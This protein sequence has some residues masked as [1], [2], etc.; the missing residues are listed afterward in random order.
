[1]R[2][3]L[4]LL[5]ALG[6][7]LASPA[8]AGT[9]YIPTPDTGA[10]SPKFYAEVTSGGT[11]RLEVTFINTGASGVGRTGTPA[12][13]DND[14][15]P[16][17]FNLTRYVVEVGMLRLVGDPG[18]DVRT[19][20]VFVETRSGKYPWALPVLTEENRFRTGETA[21]LYGLARTATGRSNVEIVNFGSAIAT[22]QLQILRPRG[23]AI[24]SPRTVSLPA[25][26]HNVV[27]DPLLGV[28]ANPTGANLRAQVTCNQPFYAYGTFVDANAAN[29]RMLYPLDT[30]AQPV[31]ETV[32]VDRP[33]VFFIPRVGNSVL[34]IPLP[35]VPGRSYRKATIEFDVRISQFTPLFTG[36]V[37]M[38]HTGG[39]RFNRT[40]YF[41]TFVR[42]LRS[43]TMIDQGSAVIEPAIVVGTGWRE[44]AEHHVKIVYDTEAA[45][46]QFQVTRNNAVVLDAF[47][48]AFN[49]DLADRG[50]PV[51]LNFGLPGVADHA[52]YPPFNWRFS[53][54][55]VRVT[56]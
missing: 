31:V 38:F 25:L 16:N 35:L 27:E 32:S 56:R 54:L 42:G 52:Y 19:G 33:G 28:I 18:P 41:G 51:R 11:R 2:K 29:F 23:S 20:A 40:L 9:F 53:N 55:T 48:S 17:A 10:G 44:N 4:S 3:P 26:S 39:Q 22:C 49:L 50:N 45:T 5:V 13:V 1:M 6:A 15:K 24:G 37:G 34:D 43:R 8:L 12:N 7:A 47:G 46:V 14:E 30:P 21:Y 36:L